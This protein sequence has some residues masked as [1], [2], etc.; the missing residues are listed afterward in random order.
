MGIHAF[1]TPGSVDEAVRLMHEGEG[2]GAYVAGGTDLVC[3]KDKPDFVVNV[4]DLLRES[5]RDNGM[6]SIGGSVT[7]TQ[8]EHWDALAECDDGLLRRCAR[9]FGSWHVRNMATAGG[10]LASA[11]PSADAAPPLLVLE[12]ECAIQGKDGERTVPLDQFFK[13]PRQ[14]ALG[15]DLL[16]AIRFP[17]PEAGARGE[18]LKICR[19]PGAIA[20]INVAALLWLDGDEITKARIALGAVA[21]TPIRAYDAEEYLQGKPASDEHLDRAAELA[22]GATKPIGDQR[23]SADYRRHMS[24]ALTKRALERC[25]RRSA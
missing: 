7:L 23:A 20:A 10:N 3:L 18:F 5:K 6:F 13:G 2:R 16:T 17:A 24:Y 4:R 8:I 11:Y 25:A 21:P 19:N 22:Q 15:Q 14:S 12:A 1:H 9:E